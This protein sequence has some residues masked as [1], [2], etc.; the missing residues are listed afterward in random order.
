M[1]DKFMRELKKQE[2]SK[3]RISISKYETIQF[4]QDLLEDENLIID[5]DTNTNTKLKAVQEILLKVSA[6]ITR[7]VGTEPI[8]GGDINA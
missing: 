3:T 5:F 7:V 4:L 8:N 2:A 1:L 6:E